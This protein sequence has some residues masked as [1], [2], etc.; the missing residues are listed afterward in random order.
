MKTKKIRGHNRIRKDIAAW[1]DYQKNIELAELLNSCPKYNTK[2]EV[3]PWAHISITNSSFAEPKSTTRQLIIL[4]L[5]DIYKT[6]KY[7]L[8]ATG[9]PYYLKIW[10]HEEISISQVV[11]ATG[12]S[13][14]FYE[15]TFLKPVSP[16]KFNAAF[17]GNVEG[18]AEMNWEHGLDV[19]CY[20]KDY[21]GD[22][23][24]YSDEE[25]FYSWKRFLNRLYQNP[26]AV[27]KN[28]D[29]SE[30]Y[31]RTNGNVWIGSTE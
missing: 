15:N 21:L 26:D 7:K 11:C 25:A 3:A 12:K 31:C 13:L 14:N 23:S 24:E 30:L 17:F 4:S 6:W 9:K 20:P 8:D 19:Q 18:L 27:I 22:K 2:I 1:C 28:N 29:G 5:I 16:K 10:L